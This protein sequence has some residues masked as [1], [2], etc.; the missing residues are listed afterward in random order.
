MTPP[1]TPPRPAFT[2]LRD[3]DR[4][5]GGR[6]PEL[7][8][9]QREIEE[10]THLWAPFVVGGDSTVLQSGSLGAEWRYPREKTQVSTLDQDPSPRYRGER[11]DA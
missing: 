4:C 7:E 9:L 11:G 10:R 1:T 3:G 8:K 2:Q 5:A 6:G